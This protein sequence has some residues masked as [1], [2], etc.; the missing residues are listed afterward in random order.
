MKLGLCSWSYNRTFASGKMDLEKCLKVCADELKVGGI[1]IIDVHF[2]GGDNVANLVKDT[3]YLMKI[4]KLAT[5]LQITIS[6]VSPGNSFGKDDPK[7]EKAEVD[8]INKWTDIAYIL[9]APNLRI[10]AGWAPKEKHE[11]LWPKVVK[12]IKECAEYAAKKGITLAIESHND[13]GYLPTSVETLKLLK[14]VDSP[15]VKLNL[16]TGNYQDPEPYAALKKSMPYVTHMHAKIH[17]LSPDCKELEFDYDKIF[18]VLKESNYRGFF[19][20]EYEGIEEEIEYVPKSFEM[21][22]RFMKKYG[23]F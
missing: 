19:N 2:K 9:G 18:K 13:G 11:E 22:R 14:D 1:D 16:D 7:D 5:D 6:A 12:S 4:K 15:W 20:V 8:K 21:I 23:T 17:K 3:T 10:F